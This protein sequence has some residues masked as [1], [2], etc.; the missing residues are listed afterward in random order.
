[1]NKKF[2][3]AVTIATTTIT[4]T[5]AHT[6]ILNAN[7]VH[8]LKLIVDGM[9]RNTIKGGPTLLSSNSLLSRK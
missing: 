1:M 9:K 7:E 5:F 3:F 4:N 6:Y 8:G 2:F